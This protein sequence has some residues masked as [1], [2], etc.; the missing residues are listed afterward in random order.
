MR[1]FLLGRLVIAFVLGTCAVSGGCV[2]APGYAS[3]GGYGAL[4]PES[5]PRLSGAVPVATDRPLERPAS[6]ELAVAE[7]GEA[8][9]DARAVRE[10]ARAKLFA[11]VTP[12]AGGPTTPPHPLMEPEQTAMGAALLGAVAEARAAGARYLMVL[13]STAEN[14][15]PESAANLPL[16]QHRTP[17]IRIQQHTRGTAS[18]VLMDVSDGAILRVWSQRGFARHVTIPHWWAGSGR[19]GRY[20]ESLLRS[21]RPKVARRA[22][23]DLRRGEGAG[24]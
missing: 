4:T 14:G 1:P 9:P 20:A 24:A 12:V 10:L 8:A 13:T 11:R 3:S 15:T 16:E 19:G 18:A 17:P 23:R 2:V 22:A 7:L 5:L 6:V 21:L